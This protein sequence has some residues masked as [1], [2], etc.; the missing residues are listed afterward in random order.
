MKKYLCACVLASVAMT[1]FALKK[2]PDYR[3]ARNLA[4]K[5][6]FASMSMMILDVAS[7]MR[8]CVFSWA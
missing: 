6:V 8:M 5:R 1:T 2:D 7:R 3:L 4:L